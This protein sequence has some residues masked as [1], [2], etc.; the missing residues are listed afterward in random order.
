MQLVAG[1]Q[2][3]GR[4]EAHAGDAGPQAAQGRGPVEI[5][6]S[7][8]GLDPRVQGFTPGLP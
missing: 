8:D 3:T 6:L 4:E 7:I 2:R 1:G 5:L